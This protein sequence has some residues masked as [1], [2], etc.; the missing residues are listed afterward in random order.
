MIFFIMQLQSCSYLQ[1]DVMRSSIKRIL[2]ALHFLNLPSPCYS[3]CI[4]KILVY[5]HLNKK[6]NFLRTSPFAENGLQVTRLVFGSFLPHLKIDKDTFCLFDVAFPCLKTA[7]DECLQDCKRKVKENV[8]QLNE[9]L[10][11]SNVLHFDL[12]YTTHNL[13][14]I[15]LFLYW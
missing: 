12:I 15:D 14:F 3:F 11:V 4:S 10:Q 13:Q 9:L 5:Y 1:W 7:F 2:F 6:H 8:E